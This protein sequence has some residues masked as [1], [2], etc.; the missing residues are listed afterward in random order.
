MNQAHMA[1]EALTALAGGCMR[2]TE[3]I[4][5]EEKMFK[6]FI[7][8]FRSPAKGPDPSPPSVLCEQCGWKVG[9]YV[10]LGVCQQYCEQKGWAV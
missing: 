4:D 8:S 9:A 7:L 1:L 5:T 6:S 3:P 2:C 10:G